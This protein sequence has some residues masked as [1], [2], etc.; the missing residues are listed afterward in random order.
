MRRARLLLGAAAL[1]SIIQAADFAGAADADAAIEQAVK[2]EL[3]PGAVLVVGHD[4]QVVYR[5]AY[6]WRALIP[7]R[8]PMT[9]DTIFDV[10]S[11]TKVVATTSCLMKL[12]EEGKLRLNDPVTAYL[13]EFQGGKT[14]ITVRN[15]MTHFSGLRPDLDLTPAWSGY[16]TGIEKALHDTPA[17]P[18]GMHM[19][20]SD[21]NYE[22]LG[23]IVRRL[24]GEPL[25]DYA[26]Q[27]LFDP[28]G[29]KDTM[30]QPPASLRPRIAPTEIDEATGLPLRGVVH[31]ETARYMG[32]IAGHAGLFSTADDLARFAQMMLDNGKI[33][34]RQLFSPATVEKFTTPQ[35]PPDQPVLR[36]LGW[37]IDS[38]F[39]SNRGELFPI[40]SYGHT[41]FTGTSIWIDPFSRTYVILLTNAVHPHRGKNLSSLRS[42]VAT[43]TA[44][45]YGYTSPE[46]ALT[47]YN[48][49]MVGAGVHRIVA[50]NGAVMNGLDVLA[51]E[52]FAPL[53]GRH[54]G[55]ITNQTGISRDGARN[56]DL[57]VRAG[58]DV[59]ALFSP[60][61]GISGTEDRE[62]IG[63]STDTA[64]GIP[65][66]SLYSGT[67]RT[68]TPEMLRGIDTLVFDI[69]DVGA[70]FYTYSCTMIYAMEE[71]ARE[72]LRFVVLDRP[73]PITGV[74]VEGPVLDRD[75]ESF[76][77]CAEIPVR[78][79]MT[80]G[81]LANMVNGTRHLGLDLEV[82]RMTGWE[83]GFWWD[84]TGLPWVDP[85]PNM[86]S[87]NAA[88]LYPGIAMLE[89]SKNYSVGRGTDAPFEQIGADWINGRKL[90]D[91]LNAQWVPGIRVYPTRFRPT[92]S[93]FKGQWIEGV[94]FVITN[95]NVFDSTRFGLE[96]AYALETLFPGKMD[97]SADRSLIGNQAVLDALG[98]RQD[99]D[100]TLE[101]LV[102]QTRAFE[103]QRDEWLLYRSGRPSPRPAR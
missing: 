99:P 37:D 74:H 85:S 25:P 16:Q 60:E 26:R 63:N 69:Q 75:L 8:E 57:M 17:G 95:R 12:F 42:R 94:R 49:T 1:C 72:H 7:A 35:T 9:V 36:G 19:V 62:N 14:D 87:L 67:T 98:R 40:G 21:I 66:R 71:A 83:R 3:I 4:G 64:T 33:D 5:K 89:Y 38:P 77:G 92:A 51:A 24:S 59:K 18:P 86:R 32:G 73:N 34:G 68:A 90:A 79:G 100:I 61:H 78:H 48:E 96:L 6:G 70:R 76:V 55:L 88:L 52:H 82:V 102:E 103:K 22:L 27:I 50:V 101:R 11:L 28:A 15:L 44:A 41:G 30:F 10:A 23:E 91:F 47:G 84:E 13:P 54:I 45:S 39:S 43:I 29:M 80:M 31:D 81:E 20:Y 65:V 58:L 53:R 56:I 97:W 46:V 2:E 93:N